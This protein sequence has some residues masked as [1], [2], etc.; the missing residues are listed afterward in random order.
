MQGSPL[1][2]VLTKFEVI[3]SSNNTNK[4]NANVKIS[5]DANQSIN[6]H[7]KSPEWNFFILKK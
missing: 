3:E 7:A 2:G 5:Q 1:K 6:E 4:V